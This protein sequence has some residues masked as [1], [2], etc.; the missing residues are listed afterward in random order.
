MTETASI[1]VELW[2]IDRIK[3][4]KKNAKIHSDDQVASVAK[5][6]QKFGWTQ[7]IVVDRDG[8]II[9]GHGRRLAA[10]SLGLKKVPVVCRTDL[11]KG[12]ADALRLADNRVASQL[13]DTDLLKDELLSLKD[14]DVDLSLTG[15][16]EKELEFLTADLGKIDTGVF[17]DDVGE[18]VE[19]Q[20]EENEAKVK[21]IDEKELPISDGF[22][23][24]KLRAAQVRRVKTFM[25]KL[26]GETGLEGPDALMAFFDEMG[27]AA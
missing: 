5:S 20:K 10:I 4:Y 27:I 11:T 19:K 6:I 2:D 18:A 7:P 8:V 23:F 16:D 17:V 21:E 9:V 25:A 26:E 3:P 15:Y 1:P 13:Y 14:L 12:E 22:G 24:K